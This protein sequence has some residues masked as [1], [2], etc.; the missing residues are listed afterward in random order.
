MIPKQTLNDLH[1]AHTIERFTNH[2]V[3][4]AHQ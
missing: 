2:L 1:F 3:F 4:F